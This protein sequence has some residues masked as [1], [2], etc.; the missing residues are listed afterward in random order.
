MYVCRHWAP[1]LW[2]LFF[3][4]ILTL[5]AAWRVHWRNS[6]IAQARA[7]PPLS[8]SVLVRPTRFR[9][10]DSADAL[11]SFL[12]PPILSTARATFLGRRQSAGET[13]RPDDASCTGIC[14]FGEMVATFDRPLGQLLTGLLGYLSSIVGAVQGIDDHVQIPQVTCGQDAPLQGTHP[15]LGSPGPLK[16]GLL[17]G[18]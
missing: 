4:N 6:T 10:A 17:L 15:V 11:I 18:P 12:P 8:R 3:C 5:C 14:F 7:S 2:R 16:D 1:T 9:V 13:L